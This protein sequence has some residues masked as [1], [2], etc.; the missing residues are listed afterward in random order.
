MEKVVGST[1]QAIQISDHAPISFMMTTLTP[2]HR[3]RIWKFP[4]YLIQ[5]DYFKA[6]LKLQWDNYLDDIISH[7]ED[8]PLFWNASKAVLI[9]QVLKCKQAYQRFQLLHQQLLQI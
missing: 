6:F 7:I 5:S 3:T 9:T 1:I 4:S 8:T 2:T